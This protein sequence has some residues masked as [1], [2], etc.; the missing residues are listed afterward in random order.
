[1]IQNG[2]ITSERAR[3][4]EEGFFIFRDVV[5]RGAIEEIVTEIGQVFCD[6]L[7][8]L[9]IDPE[10]GRLSPQQA[11]KRLFDLNL[12]R[13]LAA[14]SVLARLA[15]VGRL[16]HSEPIWKVVQRL[17][18]RRAAIPTHPVTHLMSPDL[19]IPDGY[20][21]LEPHQDW[22]SLQGSLDAFVVWVPLVDIDAGMNP[23]ELIPRSHRNGLMKAEVGQNE[24]VIDP[25]LFRESDFIPLEVRA[26]DV[27]VLSSFTVHRSSKVG[28]TGAVR[29]A[30]S[31]RY[32]NMEER[33]YAERGYPSAYKR[34][35]HRDL[36]VAGFPS[37]QQVL[38]TFGFGAAEDRESA[39]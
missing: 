8:M 34:S 39:R 2:D 14:T 17:G 33:T 6:Q 1:M 22:P 19:Q 3:Y 16:L 9:G 36:Y 30:C 35:I 28:R 5:D 29:L 10:A 20:Y 13:Y 25:R 37:Q 12:K 32:E 38:K 15:G 18:C 11:M 21:G 23:L 24:S 4:N 26:G 7:R 31:T 27:A